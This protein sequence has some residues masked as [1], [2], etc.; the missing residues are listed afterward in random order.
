MVIWLAH[1]TYD[2]SD[3]DLNKNRLNYNF[4]NAC[5]DGCAALL[6]I[7]FQCGAQKSNEAIAKTVEGFLTHPVICVGLKVI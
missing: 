4:H 3:Q 5:R 6:P 1:H 2:S 7:L